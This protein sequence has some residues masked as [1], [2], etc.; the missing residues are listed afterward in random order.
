MDNVFNWN[1]AEDKQMLFIAASYGD[2]WLKVKAYSIMI[3]WYTR[4]QFN[5]VQIYSFLFIW[6]DLRTSCRKSRRVVFN[7]YKP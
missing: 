1:S 3:Q 2:P 7:L 4:N 6:L 5:K